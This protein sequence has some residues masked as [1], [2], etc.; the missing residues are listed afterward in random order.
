MFSPGDL[1]NQAS[2]GPVFAS[3]STIGDWIIPNPVRDKPS[4]ICHA[5]RRKFPRMGR[6]YPVI[7]R[8][9]TRGK[10]SHTAA[11]TANVG[12]GGILLIEESSKDVH[13]GEPVTLVIEVPAPGGSRH[14]KL[15]LRG[16]GRVVRQNGSDAP[17][18]AVRVVAIMFD[19]PLSLE[20]PVTVS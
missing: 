19:R 10:G 11:R 16:S 6:E 15:H 5:E 1:R 4:M 20:N 13:V 18:G 14:Q 9:D 3:G 17:S 8:W 2:N 12:A 7:V